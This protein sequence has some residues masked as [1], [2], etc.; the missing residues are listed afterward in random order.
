MKESKLNNEKIYKIR[1]KGIYIPY[2]FPN[3]K[4]IILPINTEN[5]DDEFEKFKEK[6]YSK[7]RNIYGLKKGK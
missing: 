5:K 2:D 7:L 6:A 3:E 1:K 4:C